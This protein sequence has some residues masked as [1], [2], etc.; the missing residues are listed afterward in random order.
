VEG[1]EQKASFRAALR[2]RR[3]LVISDGFYEWRRVSEKGPKQPYLIRR[4]NGEPMGLAGLWETWSDPTGGEIDTACIITTGANQLMSNVRERMPA[5]LPRGAFSLWLDT[6]GVDPATAVELLTPADEGA[7]ELVPI[8]TGINRA[9]ND[10]AAVQAPVGEALR[11]RTFAD[12]SR[13][14]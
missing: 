3:C 11:T 1:I 7:L 2:R 8:G 9:E 5:I 10:E 14:S 6:D 12:S 4:V 13:L